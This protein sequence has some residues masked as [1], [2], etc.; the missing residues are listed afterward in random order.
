[1]PRLRLATLLASLISLAIASRAS[2]APD[3]LPPLPP[4][5]RVALKEDWSTG[6][7]DPAKWYALRKKWGAGNNGVVPENLH[8]EPDNVR[9]ER[10]NVLVCQANGD[11][12]D[13]PVIGDGGRKRRVGEPFIHGPPH[14]AVVAAQLG[15][16][17]AGGDAVKQQLFQLGGAV[18]LVHGA[19]VARCGRGLNRWGGRLLGVSRTPH[20]GR[21]QSN[22]STVTRCDGRAR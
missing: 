5:A 16:R 20:G 13:G 7:I 14:D 6:S 12:Y 9:G 15:Q 8:I 17:G 11:Q 2:A 18:S 1:M 22:L 21:A 10:R 3:D 19:G 4:G